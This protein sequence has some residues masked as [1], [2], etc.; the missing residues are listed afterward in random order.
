[1]DNVTQT[2]ATVMD[3][4]ITKAKANG[5]PAVR[6]I[7]V[8][9]VV[10]NPTRSLQR[11]VKIALVVTTNNETL[12][13]ALIQECLNIDNDVYFVGSD[14]NL[15]SDMEIDYLFFEAKIMAKIK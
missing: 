3:F 4:L 5:Q 13:D 8:N 6:A 2:E 14:V 12:V 7:V 10:D 15:Q 1:M 11:I 9:R